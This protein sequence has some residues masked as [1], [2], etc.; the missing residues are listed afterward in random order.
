MNNNGRKRIST[1]DIQEWIGKLREKNI[2]EFEHR[3]LPKELQK[4]EFIIK[5]KE[6]GFIRSIKNI[7]GRNTWRIVDGVSRY[8]S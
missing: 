3:T 6:E 2:R 5:A 1:L 7:N 4:R 8:K